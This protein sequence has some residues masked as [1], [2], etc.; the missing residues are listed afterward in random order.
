L[1]NQA[2]VFEVTAS[3]EQPLSY[4]W[5]RNTM[6]IQ[7][8]TA[9]RLSLSATLAD[10]GARFSVT[11]SNAG[12]AITSNQALLQVE[13]AGV[14][15]AISANP[16]NVSAQVG[17][18]AVFDVQATGTAPLTYQW[19]KNGVSIPGAVQQSLVITGL[20]LADNGA[21]FSVDVSNPFGTE[22]S[23]AA[24]LSVS[25]AVVPPSIGTLQGPGEVSRGTS[26]TFSVVANGTPPFQFQW[27]RDGVEIPGATLESY[28]RNGVTLDDHLTAYTVV[29]SNAGGTATSKPILLRV[30][31]PPVLGAGRFF[32]LGASAAVG[33]CS[34][35]SNNGKTLGRDPGPGLDRSPVPGLV[36]LPGDAAVRQVA[37]GE[38]HALALRSDGT[39]WAWGF[40]FDGQ[41]GIGPF[42]FTNPIDI[43][44][45][46]PT[47]VQFPPTTLIRKIAAG[48]NFSL[49]LDSN[50]RVW[51]WGENNASQT[52]NGKVGGD[53]PFN[54]AS[55]L[56]GVFLPGPAAIPPEIQIV[57][58]AAAN[59]YGLALTSQ[60][61]IWGWGLNRSGVPSSNVPGALDV[62]LVNG[63]RPVSIAAAY[64]QAMF[65][66]D[67]GSAWEWGNGSLHAG[68]VLLEVP[69]GLAF[70]GFA[71]G[72]RHRLYLMSD[73][74]VHASGQEEFGALGNGQAGLNVVRSFVRT[75]RIGPPNTRAIAIAA[76]ERHSLAILSDGSVVGWG[77]NSPG[78]LGDGTQTTRLEPVSSS[79]LDLEPPLMTGCL[80]SP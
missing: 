17:Q 25:P 78:Q 24:V 51:G 10:D 70:V 23:S 37:A 56:N 60:G 58:I 4:Q 61:V 33:L 47:L 42:S 16:S 9:P 38:R 57:D 71:G 26:A 3:G 29:M 52:G 2:A 55:L 63:V 22:S 75:L 62:G 59:D 77:A 41:L 39:V 15:P 49:A 30:A 45:A 6:P 69:P 7:G 72:E 19:R 35:G 5:L 65:I 8:A 13:P 73:G 21:K 36:A 68:R 66:A 53:I 44:F 40:N 54:G 76:G 18:Q 50:G 80:P 20:S 12:G 43:E 34:W 64:E 31:E 48:R 14:A 1:A 11:V 32:S 27:R 28:T 46:V 67:D 74:T 79:G